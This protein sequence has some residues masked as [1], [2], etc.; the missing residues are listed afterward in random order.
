MTEYC[1]HVI[2][3]PSAWTAADIARDERWRINLSAADIAELDAAVQAT[4]GR[5]VTTISAAEFDLPQLSI[6]MAAL[7]REID[8]GTRVCVD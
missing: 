7:G 5:E 4:A 2:D 3:H 1:D 8:E 6:R